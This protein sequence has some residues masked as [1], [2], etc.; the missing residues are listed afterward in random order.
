M[1]E[2]LVLAKI[3]SAVIGLSVAVFGLMFFAL[4]QNPFRHIKAMLAVRILIA[5][6]AYAWLL[7]FITPGALK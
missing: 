3:S 5:L 7:Y 1:S 4:W 2:I 6:I